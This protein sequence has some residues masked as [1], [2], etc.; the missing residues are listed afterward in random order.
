MDAFS[1]VV[2]D[3]EDLDRAVVGSD[4]VRNH[5]GELCRVAGLDQD[6]PLPHLQVARSARMLAEWS[7]R[8]IGQLANQDDPVITRALASRTTE[9]LLCALTIMITCR[10][11]AIDLT[12]VAHPRSVTVPGYPAT[13]LHDEN[14]PWQRALPV[15]R[16]LGADT[17]VFWAEIAEHGLRVPTSWLVP[18]GW[19]AL[20]SRAHTHRH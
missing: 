13:V 18:S 20:W 7:H 3:D 14:G 6:G 8:A 4:G 17:H 19:T 10:T 16:E 5:G 1:V 15:A 9:Q 2:E 11:P 12:P